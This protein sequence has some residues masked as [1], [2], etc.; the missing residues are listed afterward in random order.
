MLSTGVTQQEV[1]SGLLAPY[2]IRHRLVVVSSSSKGTTVHI[3][4]R[5]SQTTSIMNSLALV[6]AL[7]DLLLL[8]RITMYS[9]W[10]PHVQP[11]AHYE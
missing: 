4:V 8:I 2:R 7:V 6:F 10:I 11:A 3:I 9:T 1:I 5:I